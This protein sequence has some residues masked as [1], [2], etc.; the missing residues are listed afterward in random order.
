[1]RQ[2]FAGLSLVETPAALVATSP[3]EV[4]AEE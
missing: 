3:E 4:F 2:K 1:M